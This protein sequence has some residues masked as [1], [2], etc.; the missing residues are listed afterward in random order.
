MLSGR[1][2]G[3][4]V[5]CWASLYAIPCSSS[6]RKS[7]TLEFRI[8]R[9]LFWKWRETEAH[10]STVASCQALHR[11]ATT[12]HREILDLASS[13]VRRLKVY[14]YQRSQRTDADESHLG[15]ATNRLF[16]LQPSS[17]EIRDREARL[18]TFTPS[19]T[20]MYAGGLW[21]STLYPAWGHHRSGRVP[22]TFQLHDPSKYMYRSQG[23]LCCF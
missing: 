1:I 22:I 3:I 10:T 21:S 13:S 15:G 14:K 5:M 12:E 18:H 6:G 8:C 7:L 2:R 11:R 23:C 19:K 17:A 4:S 20:E 16:Y 9:P